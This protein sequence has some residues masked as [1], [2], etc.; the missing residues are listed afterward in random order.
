[1]KRFFY[2]IVFLLFALFAF[3]LNLQNPNTI[4]IAY[5]FD[6][7]W[8]VPLFLV[9]MA[10][11]FIGMILGVVIMSLSVF[12]NKRQVGKAKREL[13]KVEKEVENLRAMPL[14]NEV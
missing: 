8:Q 13:K 9:I 7:S 11:F 2:L 1:M 12:K 5:Y 3:T 10:P 4:A 14:K 6:I